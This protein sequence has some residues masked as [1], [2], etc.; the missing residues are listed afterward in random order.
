MVQLGCPEFAIWQ[1]FT[2]GSGALAGYLTDGVELKLVFAFSIRRDYEEQRN[3]SYLRQVFS[4]VSL[5]DLPPALSRV[6]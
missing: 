1:C 6:A 2:A 5:R 4:N 3:E